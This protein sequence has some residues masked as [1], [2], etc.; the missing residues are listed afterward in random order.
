MPMSSFRGWY[1]DGFAD[2]S[3][4]SKGMMY[5]YHRLLDNEIVALIEIYKCGQ[6][7]MIKTSRLA[8]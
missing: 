5:I 7:E 8:K 6:I 1:F 4:G 2:S 3:D